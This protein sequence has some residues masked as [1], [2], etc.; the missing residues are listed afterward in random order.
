MINSQILLLFNVLNAAIN[1]YKPVSEYLIHE[2]QPSWGLKVVT[3]ESVSTKMQVSST[4]L[5]RCR[6]QPCLSGSPVL[7]GLPHVFTLFRVSSPIPHIL[8]DKM[9]GINEK[10][11]WW[12]DFTQTITI[13]RG[14]HG[15]QTS[16]MNAS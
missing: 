4:A 8:F 9:G 13:H 14:N 3:A 11:K 6:M 15:D 10:K 5:S 7:L 2:Y 1:S 16:Y 12:W